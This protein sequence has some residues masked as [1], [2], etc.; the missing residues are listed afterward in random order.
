MKSLHQFIEKH[1]AE[2]ENPLEG[3]EISLEV[4]VSFGPDSR[5]VALRPEWGTSDHYIAEIIPSRA[6]DY[7]FR[8]FGTIGEQA[9]DEGFT[10]TA[11]E[12]SSVEPVSDVSFPD[13]IPQPLNFWNKLKRLTLVLRRLKL[14]N[15]L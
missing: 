12:F 1:D 4:E 13:A 14:A 11:G 5:T 9:I 6:G 7:S 10:S 15:N 8:V 2:G 3:I